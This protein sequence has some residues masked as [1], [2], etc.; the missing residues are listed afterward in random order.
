[1]KHRLHVG[2][3]SNRFLSEER[4]NANQVI[5]SGQVPE[6]VD[7]LVMFPGALLRSRNNTDLAWLVRV[8]DR[9]VE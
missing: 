6:E 7:R 1:M 2:Q 4:Q 5:L 3:K 9:M 8:K